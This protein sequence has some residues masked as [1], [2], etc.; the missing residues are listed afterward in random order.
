MPGRGLITSPDRPSRGLIGRGL[1]RGGGASAPPEALTAPSI[2]GLFD[3]ESTLTATP[4]TYTGAA[5]VAGQWQRLDPSGPTW[6]DIVGETSLTYVIDDALDYPGGLRYQE[7]ATNSAGSVSQESNALSHWSA[8]IYAQDAGVILGAYVTGC[9][10]VGDPVAAWHE[11]RRTVTFVQ[12]I[13]SRQPL[14]SAGGPAWDGLDDFLACD[15]EAGRL[16]DAHTVV[17][18]WS[19]GNANNTTQIVWSSTNA[20]TSGVINRMAAFSYSDFA[21]AARC[22]VRYQDSATLVTVDLQSLGVVGTDGATVATR[23]EGLGADTRCDTLTD[24][25]VQLGATVTRPA[26]P[27]AFT[28]LTL[29]GFRRSAGDTFLNPWEGRMQAWMIATRSYGDAELE[30][31]RLA[32]VAGGVI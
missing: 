29:G 5:T 19:H 15:A 1:P 26:T 3:W 16:D 27:L 32:L 2:A 12:G 22:N 7:T 20:D 4:G 10:D 14:M 24:P 28:R 11:V 25:L 30:V 31:V 6:S 18:A 23:C 21:S 9:P 8:P 13:T 17:V